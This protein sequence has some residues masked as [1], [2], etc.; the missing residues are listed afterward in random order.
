ME[1]GDGDKAK[2]SRC[3]VAAGVDRVDGGVSPVDGDR[4]LS[5]ECV[6]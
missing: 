3:D 2:G 4:C 5:I 1:I 6:A